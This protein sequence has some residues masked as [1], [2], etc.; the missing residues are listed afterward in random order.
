MQ[1][2]ECFLLEHGGPG[3][4]AEGAMLDLGGTTPTMG[5]GGGGGVHTNAMATCNQTAFQLFATMSM[6]ESMDL[7]FISRLQVKICHCMHN[8]GGPVQDA[9]CAGTS[10]SR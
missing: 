8:D 9:D 4:N 7:D 1:H 6:A 3:A 2:F 10:V 5:G